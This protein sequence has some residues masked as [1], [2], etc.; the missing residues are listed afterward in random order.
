[1]GQGRGGLLREYTRNSTL[2][3]P[4]TGKE[5]FHLEALGPVTLPFHLSP[6]PPPPPPSLPPLRFF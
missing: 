5:K 6:P 4:R 1:M 2:A 3:A